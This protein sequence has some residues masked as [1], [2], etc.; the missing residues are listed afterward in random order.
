MKFHILNFIY[1][2]LRSLIYIAVLPPSLFSYYIYVE[3]KKSLVLWN[4]PHF[5]FGW[6]YLHGIFWY[7]PLCPVILGYLRLNLEQMSA[8]CVACGPAACFLSYFYKYLFLKHSYAHLF[9][10]FLWLLQQ[11]S[12]RIM[13]TKLYCQ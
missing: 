4:F 7:L 3:E 10:Y 13:T 5:V 9:M 6:V 1:R 2:F 11:Q 8:D 12:W